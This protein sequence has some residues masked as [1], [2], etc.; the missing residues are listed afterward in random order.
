MH[1]ASI[2]CPQIDHFPSALAALSTKTILIFYLALIFSNHFD[3][4][5]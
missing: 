1:G 5:N 2:T 3:G 4:K